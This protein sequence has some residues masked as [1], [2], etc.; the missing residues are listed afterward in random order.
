MVLRIAR[1]DG[2]ICYPRLSPNVRGRAETTGLPG[3]DRF[4]LLGSEGSG[5][6]ERDRLGGRGN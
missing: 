3:A 2:A 4:S 5:G 1:A 6:D